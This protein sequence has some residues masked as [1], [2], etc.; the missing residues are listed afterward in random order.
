[1]DSRSPRRWSGARLPS[2]FARLVQWPT[3][4]G[5][6]GSGSC[7]CRDIWPVP[8]FEKNMLRQFARPF[9]LRE[10]IP[11]RSVSK[12]IGH[13]SGAMRINGFFYPP[14]HNLPPCEMAFYRHAQ[15]RTPH[16][17]TSL[18]GGRERSGKAS[19]ML[20]RPCTEKLMRSY[21]GELLR[22]K[23]PTLA[24]RALQDVS[25]IYAAHQSPLSP[26]KYSLFQ[27]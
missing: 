27:P 19:P 2:W 5:S 17:Q 10:D 26:S 23:I 9:A 24:V 4:A 14:D 1:M 11:T 18:M 25:R 22:L 12:G 6:S 7:T 16:S 13:F 21:E 3:G 8:S 15:L 20:L